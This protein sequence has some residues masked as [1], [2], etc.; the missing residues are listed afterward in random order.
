MS[1]DLGHVLFEGAP[2][3]FQPAP[4]PSSNYYQFVDPTL[5]AIRGWWS[6]GSTA[7]VMAGQ[8]GFF[9]IHFARAD[10]LFV[11]FPRSY[12]RERKWQ[13]YVR[14]NVTCAGSD[15]WMTDHRTPATRLQSK[16]VD[17]QT[18]LLTD[19]F[20]GSGVGHVQSES[21]INAELY[22]LETGFTIR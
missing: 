1:Y 22:D 3:L 14:Q 13:T 21:L 4:D 12:R 20:G 18:M 6:G 15:I 9:G 11:E 16:W 8:Q 10:Q 2:D 17:A 5:P 7:G 19:Q